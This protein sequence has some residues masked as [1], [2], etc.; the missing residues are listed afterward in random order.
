MWLGVG[1]ARH[2]EIWAIFALTDPLRHGL[3]GLAASAAFLALFFGLSLQ[4]WIA[5]VMALIVYGA[6]LLAT[7]RYAPPQERM[8]AD[9]VTESELDQ[10]VATLNG[11]AARLTALFPRAPLEVA[12]AIED[13]AARLA[14]IAEHHRSDPR[15]VRHTRNFIRHD[16]ERMV[17]T[18]EKFVDLASRSD[19]TDGARLWPISERIRGFAPALAKIEQASLDADFF[20]LE[21]EAEVLSDQIGR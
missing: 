13:M 9:D 15:D 8:V 7:P 10:A 5:A 4:L 17:E 21:I 2:R 11:A 3:A 18:C 16:L 20:R 12:D 6:T 14:R 19:P 1:R